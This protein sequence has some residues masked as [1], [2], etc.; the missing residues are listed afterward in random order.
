MD[1][2]ILVVPGLQK[3][4]V[5]LDPARRGARGILWPAGP[6]SGKK[7]GQAGRQA[8]KQRQQRQTSNGTTPPPATRSCRAMLF[9]FHDDDNDLSMPHRDGKYVFR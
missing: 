1:P 7:I 4:A 6:E 2:S 3:P 5:G 8:S 9:L